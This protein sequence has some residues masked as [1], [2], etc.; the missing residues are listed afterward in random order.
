MKDKI[1]SYFKDIW[2]NTVK[3][4]TLLVFLIAPLVAYT[5]AEALN[6]RSVSK[7]FGFITGR[8]ITFLLNYLIVLFTMS[9]VL[10][11]KKVAYS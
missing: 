7:F 1:I 5:I 8:P 11:L 9:F 4:I 10:I 6:Q 3:R 2:A